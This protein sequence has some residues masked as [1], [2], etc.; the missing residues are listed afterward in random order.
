MNSQD[1]EAITPARPEAGHGATTLTVTIVIPAYNRAEALKRTLAAVTPAVSPAVEVMVVDDCSATAEVEAACALYAGRVRYVRTPRNSGVIGARN[2]AYGMAEG[3]I[4]VNLDDDSHFKSVDILDR[5]IAEFARNPRLGII[6]YNIE[7]PA[8]LGLSAD[9]E[10]F[11]CYT[12]TGC[13]N[14]IRRSAMLQAGL[15][16]PY[17][18]R[19]GEE[20]EHTLRVYD[21]GYEAFTYP[22]M[23]V[24]HEESP[25]N[26]DPRAHTSYHA[27]NYLKRV[28][29]LYPMSTI[30]VGVAR[31]LGFLV[32]HRK[33]MSLSQVFRELGRRDRGLAAAL[34]DRRPVS[35]ATFREVQ[36]IKRIEALIRARNAA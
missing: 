36:N 2:Y 31:W 35:A 15:L 28:A 27:A 26:R 8:G 14:A 9:A 18:W 1:L 7:T 4:I 24:E 13:G 6:A 21:A 12:Y 20:I 3:D 33:S 11:R 19:Q 22:D 23:I 16:S 30:P 32:K 25:I 34:R 5:S 17:F 29:L 10:P